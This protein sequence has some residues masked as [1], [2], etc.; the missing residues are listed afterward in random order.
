MSLSVD[1]NRISQDVLQSAFIDLDNSNQPLVKQSVC[2]AQKYKL[3]GQEAWEVI[4]KWKRKNK[5]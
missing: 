5:R 2:I 1:S 3:T 4:K